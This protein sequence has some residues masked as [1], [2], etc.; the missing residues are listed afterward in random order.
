MQFELASDFNSTKEKMN[1]MQENFTA[2]LKDVKGS[3]KDMKCI[4][5]VMIEQLHFYGPRKGSCSSDRNLGSFMN[6]IL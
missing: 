2:E 1:N 5:G 6:W 3:L 4:F